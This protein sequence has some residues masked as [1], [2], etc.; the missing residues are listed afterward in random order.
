MSDLIDAAAFADWQDMPLTRALH[1][2]LKTFDGRSQGFLSAFFKLSGDWLRSKGA[3]RVHIWVLEHPPA[4]S[5]NCHALCHVPADL[6]NDYSRKQRR[7][8]RQ[9]GLIWKPR[10][11]KSERIADM[12]NKSRG[13]QSPGELLANLEYLL[14]YMMK[15]G[16]PDACA[17]LMLDDEWQG[18]IRGKRCGVSENIS[19]AARKAKGYKPP[20]NTRQSILFRWRCRLSKLPC[21]A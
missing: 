2:N 6:M 1:F 10:T 16:R 15:G 17:A 9:A 11:L 21:L 7:W 19:I 20:I 14:G 18:Y 13:A 5:L 12:H 8:M 4:Q 3:P